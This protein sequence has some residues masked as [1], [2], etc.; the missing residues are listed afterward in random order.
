[1]SS[2]AERMIIGPSQPFFHPLQ[3]KE[4]TPKMI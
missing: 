1:M 4:F 2:E 3:G